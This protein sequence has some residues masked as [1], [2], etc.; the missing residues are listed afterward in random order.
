MKNE[1]ITSESL[2]Q[3]Q[4]TTLP[5]IEPQV[6]PA[7]TFNPKKIED[8]EHHQIYDL[9]SRSSDDLFSRSSD[10]PFKSIER[11]NKTQNSIKDSKFVF[12]D[13]AVNFVYIISYLTEIHEQLIEYELDYS[14]IN[15]TDFKDCIDKIKGLLTELTTLYKKNRYEIIIYMSLFDAIE[16][17]FISLEVFRI[18][19]ELQ[20][21]F[22]NTQFNLEQTD[23][24]TN[25][26]EK[27]DEN[28]ITILIIINNINIFI[29]NYKKYSLD[30]TNFTLLNNKGDSI[31]TLLSNLTYKLNISIDN[32]KEIYRNIAELE[33]KFDDELFNEIGDF[34]EQHKD[35]IIPIEKKVIEKPVEQFEE[36]IN[37]EDSKNV[38]NYITKL[39]LKHEINLEH[40]NEILSIEAN[41]YNIKNRVYSLESQ[42]YEYTDMDINISSILLTGLSKDVDV[43]LTIIVKNNRITSIKING[44]NQVTPYLDEE[45]QEMVDLFQPPVLSNKFSS[46]KVKIIDTGEGNKIMSTK[47][48]VSFNLKL[49]RILEGIAF[50]NKRTKNLTREELLRLKSICKSHI[51][52]DYLQKLDNDIFHNFN[53]LTAIYEFDTKLDDEEMKKLRASKDVQKIHVE[54][55]HHQL[56]AGDFNLAQFDTQRSVITLKDLPEI[57]NSS[58]FKITNEAEMRGKQKID[59]SKLKLEDAVKSTD[60][61]DKQNDEENIFIS[62]N[63]LPLFDPKLIENQKTT[64][65]FVINEHKYIKF[66]E[67]ITIIRSLIK[68]LDPITDMDLIKEL[69]HYDENITEPIWS[70]TIHGGT[71]ED[72]I[73]FGNIDTEID[74]IELICDDFIDHVNR[75]ENLFKTSLYKLAIKALNENKTTIHIKNDILLIPNN[76]KSALFNK[77]LTKEQ[78][79]KYINKIFNEN[80]NHKYEKI[81]NYLELPTIFKLYRVC[82]LDTFD[83]INEITVLKHLYSKILHLGNYVIELNRKIS[84]LLYNIS[85]QTEYNLA[86]FNIN[87]DI[88]EQLINVV[89]ELYVLLL[90][91]PDQL[92]VMYQNINIGNNALLPFSEFSS[93]NIKTDKETLYILVKNMTLLLSFYKE[94]LMVLNNVF[95]GIDNFYDSP[96]DKSIFT[97]EFLTKSM[98]ETLKFNEN[99]KESNNLFDNFNFI[100]DLTGFFT[101]STIHLNK[102][103]LVVK[104]IRKHAKIKLE[105]TI[106]DINP[107][108]LVN[109]N[110]FTRLKDIK[111]YDKGTPDSLNKI[112][113]EFVNLFDHLNVFNKHEKLIKPFYDYVTKQYFND[114]FYKTIYNNTIKLWK[115]RIIKSSI[116][117][118]EDKF[119]FEMLQNTIAIGSSESVYKTYPFN[120][121]ESIN[122]HKIAFIFGNNKIISEA[123]YEFFGLFSN[124]NYLLNY[125]IKISHNKNYPV[126]SSII[127]EDEFDKFNKSLKNEIR[128][129]QGNKNKFLNDILTYLDSISTE[130]FAS[131]LIVEMIDS[132]LNEYSNENEFTNYCNT[133]HLYKKIA[134]FNLLHH[135]LMNTYDNILLCK[136]KL[137]YFNL[138]KTLSSVYST[139]TNIF[140]TPIYLECFSIGFLVSKYGRLDAYVINKLFTNFLTLNTGDKFKIYRLSICIQSLNAMMIGLPDMFYRLVLRTINN[141]SSNLLLINIDKEIVKLTDILYNMLS[142]IIITD[143]QEKIKSEYDITKTVNKLVQIYNK[144][145]PSIESDTLNVFLEES[146]I[147]LSDRS[148]YYF[149]N[150][151]SN[152]SIFDDKKTIQTIYMYDEMMLDFIFGYKYE[153]LGLSNQNKFS[154]INYINDLGVYDAYVYIFEKYKKIII[155]YLNYLNSQDN[156]LAEG[157]IEKT[158]FTEINYLLS[159]MINLLTKLNII[160]SEIKN[161]KQILLYCSYNLSKINIKII[162]I[163]KHIEQSPLKLLS[164]YKRGVD[165]NDENLQNK[166]FEEL[167]SIINVNTEQY[168]NQLMT[169]LR[170]SGPLA[171]NTITINEE[172]VIREAKLLSDT[173]VN[174]EL[175]D[176]RLM[177][178]NFSYV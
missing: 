140:L 139:R 26:M 44:L 87:S 177:G 39:L 43:N 50:R 25:Y 172:P 127:S 129:Y 8:P 17:I 79:V 93:K 16:L 84:L 29:K 165:Y 68:Y 61:Y 59:E 104:N 161:A 66:N 15:L 52:K 144:M 136:L 112:I 120:S 176:R 162:K 54:L 22:N 76:Y 148:L 55:L 58:F 142:T 138:N 5:H 36:V 154:D 166:A 128:D 102:L 85:S 18:K 4:A 111:I 169:G 113:D 40:F 42:Q 116:K 32:I 156:Y 28:I 46:D 57:I 174:K 24:I 48:P 100:L 10:E 60:T 137:T 47:V 117:Y 83:K 12:T 27:L 131:A 157:L 158:A 78:Y 70:S 6:R 88:F 134:K 133:A 141:L 107:L 152:K 164:R 122:N 13:F 14:K 19:Y 74:F 38:I 170:I 67:F 49:L 62:I 124:P 147:R 34:L 101:F 173:I 119:L 53:I 89:D 81:R 118:N 151:Y 11:P 167:N 73:L 106:N 41:N 108:K 3:S 63:P 150:S 90:S 97:T 123:I 130:A 37:E 103:T 51:D 23:I 33:I 178:L 168:I 110:L 2:F 86:D 80:N 105:F 77:L 69:L 35:H 175:L 145:I 82:L 149:Y 146:I 125:T 135:I 121:G 171:Y 56:S 91:L 143:H 126:L 99:K 20:N 21:E 132:N 163:R 7:R 153:S 115:R 31:Y 64:K 30:K 45:Q 71:I 9:F 1:D 75:N 95:S 96:T 159:K 65:G 160:K 98:I 155:K 94:N 72:D 114:Q 109:N 92:I